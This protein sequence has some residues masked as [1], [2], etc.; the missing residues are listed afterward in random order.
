[1]SGAGRPDSCRAFVAAPANVASVGSGSSGVSWAARWRLS[2]ARTAVRSAP[3]VL[4]R[5]VPAPRTARSSRN[6]TSSTT[7]GL[8]RSEPVTRRPSGSWPDTTSPEVEAVS[9]PDPRMACLSKNSRRSARPS[10][11]ASVTVTNGRPSAHRAT[12]TPPPPSTPVLP[13]RTVSGTICPASTVSVPKTV[14]ASCPPPARFGASGASTGTVAVSVPAAPGGAADATPGPT[15]TPEP[16]TQASTATVIERLG[17]ATSIY[18]GPAA[19]AV[20]GATT[21]K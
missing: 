7:P 20:G 21:G 12:P 15:A 18:I 6:F 19:V 14:R 1:M 3:R 2:T 10:E 11:L 17:T 13:S 5:A 9:T 4:C 16:T 8:R